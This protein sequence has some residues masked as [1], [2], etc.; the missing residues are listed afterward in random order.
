MDA[1]RPYAGRLGA[2]YAQYGRE[3]ERLGRVDR[4]LYA[5]RALDALRSQPGSWGRDEVFFYG[6]DEL[7]ALERDAVETLSRI[8]GVDVTVSLTYEPGRPALQA[9]AAAVQ[10]L[11][12]L[13]QRVRELPAL[14]EHYAAESRAALHHLERRLFEPGGRADRPGD[15]GR[16]CSK[17]GGERAE[18]ELIAGEVVALLRPAACAARR[19][20]SCARS[21]PA[22][23]PLFE[24][25]FAQYGIAVRRG[26]RAA[27]VAHAAGPRA[28]RRGAVR[29][30]LTAR[31]ARPRTCSITSALPGCSRA[32]RSPIAS[33]RGSG[34]RACA[35]SRRR[36]A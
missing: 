7:T 8:A 33:R 15:R 25:V 11:T 29:A 22:A 19:S 3:L 1:A 6:F 12:A 27:A 30:R 2:I 14:D 13:A 24:S 32:P 21:A 31:G 5:W 28:A 23:A 16:A 35:R 9:R 36:P 18:A 4:E 10:E 34:A 20:P 17:A 26:A